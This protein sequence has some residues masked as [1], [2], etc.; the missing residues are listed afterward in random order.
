MV[1]ILS[2]S[3]YEAS[4]ELC[5]LFGALARRGIHYRMLVR[6][7]IPPGLV[8][9]NTG[10][11][12]KQTWELWAQVRLKTGIKVLSNAREKID[13]TRISNSLCEWNL[14]DLPEATGLSVSERETSELGN[15]RY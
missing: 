3:V 7:M 11:S 9:A 10:S 8:Y 14:C 5:P 1:T 13:P 4:E 6:G 15:T 12:V 2:E